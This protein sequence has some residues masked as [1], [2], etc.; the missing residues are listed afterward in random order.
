MK[1]LRLF[2]E[3]YKHFLI[4]AYF[5]IYM[6]WF[7]IL[8]ATVTTDYHLIHTGL[9]DLIP[10]C[11]YFIIPYLLWFAYV[12]AGVL[13]LAFSNVKDYYRLCTVLFTGMTIFLIASTV[14]PN[15]HNLRPLYFSHHNFCTMLVEMI[16]SNDTPTNLFPSIHC[17]NSL[18][19]EFAVFHNEKLRK[20]HSIQI[21]SLLLCIAIILATMF[22]KQHS[23]FDVLTAFLCAAILYIIVYRF[24]IYFFHRNYKK[25]PRIQRASF[26][27]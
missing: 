4:L 9:D 1:K 26:R 22:L 12:A 15:G 20:N 27:S 21:L 14:Y 7:M 18:A 11:E 3:R 2:Y 16:Y 24:D 8:E 6:P 23:T 10:F 5:L 17:F 25:T 13:Y 19:V